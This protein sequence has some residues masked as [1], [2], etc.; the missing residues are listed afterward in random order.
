MFPF[1]F[2]PTPSPPLL[3]QL[4]KFSTFVR[5][6]YTY[7]R[8]ALILSFGHESFSICQN[9][10]IISKYHLK[11]KG[12][13]SNLKSKR[14][15][16]D[17]SFSTGRSFTI[18]CVSWGGETSAGGGRAGLPLSHTSVFAWAGPG[19]VPDTIPPRAGTVC[20]TC[21]RVNI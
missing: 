13:V 3:Q 19:T 12:S 17:I 5:T 11:I 14:K 6:I 21:L 8:N 20:S 4:Q 1:G 18:A 9:T 7:S 15:R 16:V 10:F 2:D